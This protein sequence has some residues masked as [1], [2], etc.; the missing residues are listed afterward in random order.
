MATVTVWTDTNI[1]FSFESNSNNFIDNVIKAVARLRKDH[2][3]E[4]EVMAMGHEF[5]INVM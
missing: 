5:Y 3:F 4:T 2:D 1:R